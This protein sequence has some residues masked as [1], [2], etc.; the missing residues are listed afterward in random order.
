MHRWQTGLIAMTCVTLGAGC[1]DVARVPL[2]PGADQVRLTRTPADVAT[3]KP[4][5]N[6]LVPNM[7]GWD[8]PDYAN[9]QHL[10]LNQVVGLGG[11]AGL[12]TTEVVAVPLGGIA[13][14]CP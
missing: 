9:A 1:A 11:N 12:V 4:V 8:R 7:P 14:Q 6:I 5:G 3:C 13:Y 2:A 10:F